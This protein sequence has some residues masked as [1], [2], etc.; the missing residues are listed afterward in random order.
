MEIGKE[1]NRDVRPSRRHGDA[2]APSYRLGEQQPRGAAP[3]L[4][5]DAPAAAFG[6]TGAQHLLQAGE[7]LRRAGDDFWKISEREKPTTGPRSLDQA[8]LD[9]E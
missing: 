6:A 9:Q 7:S 4:Q 2:P 5:I 8:A 3:S 1:V